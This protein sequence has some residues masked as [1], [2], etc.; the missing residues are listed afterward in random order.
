MGN[1][2]CVDLAGTRVHNRQ[3]QA[4]ML[5]LDHGKL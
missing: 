5:G 4:D 2:K 1:Q 3:V